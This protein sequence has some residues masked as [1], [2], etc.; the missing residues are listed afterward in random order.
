MNK[1]KTCCDCK[2]IAKS[3]VDPLNKNARI[4]L[5]YPPT[6]H[7]ASVQ[8]VGGV[9]TANVSVYP[10]VSTE[11]PVCGEYTEKESALSS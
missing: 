10:A 3:P 6:A 1:S 2:Y 4:C 11:N 5:R 9:Q 7:L 8:T